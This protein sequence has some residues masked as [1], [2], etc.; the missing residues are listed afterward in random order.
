MNSNPNPKDVGVLPRRHVGSAILDHLDWLRKGHRATSHPLRVGSGRHKRA[1]PR[2]G[3]TAAHSPSGERRA[4][5]S[6][7]VG[8]AIAHRQQPRVVRSDLGLGHCREPARRRHAHL[9]VNVARRRAGQRAAPHLR[10][11]GHR[12]PSLSLGRR[13]RAVARSGEE[14]R[15][16]MENDLGFSV[17][18]RRAV[19]LFSRE[20]RS[21]VDRR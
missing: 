5:T 18:G 14:R 2:D 21:T 1:P 17:F 7:F 19:V 6:G 16:E 8:G 15:G 13:A 4:S 9:R 3:S 11:A 10:P 20:S 12:P